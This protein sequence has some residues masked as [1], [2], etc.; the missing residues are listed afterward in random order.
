MPGAVTGSPLFQH[1]QL[2]RESLTRVHEHNI[3][4]N[5][6]FFRPLK[7]CIY[8]YYNV[9]EE[10]FKLMAEILYFATTWSP[11][12]AAYRRSKFLEV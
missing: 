1:C 2:G 5:E 12:R 8:S 4:Y 10:N 11:S 6:C 3:P 7:P 9:S